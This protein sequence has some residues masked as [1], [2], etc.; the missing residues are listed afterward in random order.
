MKKR[1]R[2]GGGERRGGGGRGEP[3]GILSTILWF[4]EIEIEGRVGEGA[5]HKCSLKTSVHWH[6]S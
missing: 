3:A 2:G 5:F 1:E 6:C 4:V